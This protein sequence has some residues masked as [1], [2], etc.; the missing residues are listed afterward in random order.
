MIVNY[1]FTCFSDDFDKPLAFSEQHSMRYFFP[2]EIMVATSR[3]FKC[4][5]VEEMLTNSPPSVDT[6]ALTYLP[7]SRF[8]NS[9]VPRDAA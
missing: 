6:W 1:D 3:L 2:S 5:G 8:R 9:C 7:Q 4:I